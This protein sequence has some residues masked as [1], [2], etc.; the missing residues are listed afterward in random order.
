MAISNDVV[1]VNGK[2]L[3]GEL[4]YERIDDVLTVHGLLE[5]ESTVNGLVAG[6]LV[7]IEGL[8]KLNAVVKSVYVRSDRNEPAIYRV[9]FLL[10]R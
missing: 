8:R 6:Q 10:Q 3:G 5:R 9:S 4:S 2:P 1:K 7:V